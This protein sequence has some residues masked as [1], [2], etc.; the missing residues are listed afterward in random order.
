MIDQLGQATMSEKKSNLFACGNWNA[1]EADR[2]F[3]TYG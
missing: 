2:L 3:S 1:I